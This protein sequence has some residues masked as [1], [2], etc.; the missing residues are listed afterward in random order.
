MKRKELRVLNGCISICILLVGFLLL[1]NCQVERKAEALTQ[2]INRIEKVFGFDK[3]EY[4]FDTYKLAD[5]QNLGDILLYQG[6]SWDS[7][8][9][10]DKISK[11]VFSIR[12]FRAE[13]PFTLV[14][15]DSCDSPMCII[16]EPNRLTYV[17]Y[18][19][20]DS[21][22]IAV[23]KK[24]FELVEESASGI[25]ETS[26]WNAMMDAK[27]D[28]DIIDKMEDAL[29]SSVD[30]WHVEKDDE[31]KLLFEKKYVEG[32]A[33]ANG[34]IL[35]ASYKDARGEHYAVFYENENYAGFY[36]LKGNPTKSSF[37]RAPLK[38]SRIS[39][40]YN[41]RRFHPIKKRRIPHLGTDYAAPSGTPIFSVADGVVEKAGFTRNNGYYVKIRHDNVYQTQYLHMRKIG[42]GIKRGVR[43]TQGQTIG[44]VGMTG[45]ATGPHVCFRFWKNGRQVNH[46]RENFAP[47]DPLP[48]SQ[49][50]DFMAQR[51]LLLE[52]LAK[53]PF[54]SQ[55]A[56][57]EDDNY[58]MLKEIQ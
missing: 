56:K 37:L 6:I 22:D 42:K 50:E 26:L 9:K 48:E 29:A 3:S 46:L 13:K 39:S 2:N 11:D 49:M 7:I 53:I 55:Q 10:L 31:F 33:V 19:I 52:D 35:A 27:L 8:V 40:R 28:I 58:A 41:L 32:K 14:R 43:V 4:T 51:D 1:E 24:E 44:Q 25:I 36:D 34:E 47:K 17:K 38:H 57:D 23:V 5:E 21:V 15:K 18:F 54:P 16:Y 20:K 30:F 45:L 12:N